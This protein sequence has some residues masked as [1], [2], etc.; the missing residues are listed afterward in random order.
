M[1]DNTP[2][3]IL[4]RKQTEEAMPKKYTVC[5]KTGGD[6]YEITASSRQEALEAALQVLGATMFESE[7]QEGKDHD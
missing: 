1:G 6:R 7:D 2:D 4:K 3:L 5:D